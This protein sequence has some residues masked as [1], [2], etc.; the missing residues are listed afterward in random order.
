M[1]AEST[2]AIRKIT[3]AALEAYYA[4]IDELHL[5]RQMARASGVSDAV[6]VSTLQAITQSIAI[7]VA[8]S[9]AT[10]DYVEK[11]YG[12]DCR[13]GWEAVALSNRDRKAREKQM[14]LDYVREMAD[15]IATS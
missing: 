2:T 9:D 8:K 1:A 13:D 6:K 10:L 11:I 7:A 15:S 12:R 3:I 5:R 4:E 14:N